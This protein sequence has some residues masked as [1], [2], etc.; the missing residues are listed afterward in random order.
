[1]QNSKPSQDSWI[2]VNHD[3]S[4]EEVVLNGMEAL[5]PDDGNIPAQFNSS[6]SPRA[7]DAA[8]LSDVCRGFRNSCERMDSHLQVMT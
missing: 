1:M 7:F 5:F 8:R 2:L 6:P 3:Y 4:W